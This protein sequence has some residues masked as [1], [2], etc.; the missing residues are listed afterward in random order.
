MN[1]V[2]FYPHYIPDKRW[3][4]LMLLF[5]DQVR[6]IVP[7]EDHAKIFNLDY[8]QELRG[9]KDNLIELISVTDDLYGKAINDETRGKVVDLV[10]QIRAGGDAQESAGVEFIQENGGGPGVRLKPTG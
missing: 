8:I 9:E 1:P 7:D 3:L 6:T 2:L 4:R 10:D 5:Y